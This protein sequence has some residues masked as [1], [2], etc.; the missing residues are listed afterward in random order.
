MAYTSTGGWADLIAVTLMDVD[1]FPEEGKF[2][3]VIAKGSGF[4]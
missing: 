2:Q 3:K 1:F 4:W